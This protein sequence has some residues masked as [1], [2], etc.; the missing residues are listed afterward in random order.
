MD[1]I[2]DPTATADKKFQEA[3]GATPATH[4]RALWLNGVQEELVKLIEE[5]GIA[6][7]SS[8]LT[9]I[10]QALNRRFAISRPTIGA[11]TAM[12]GVRD[13]QAF[14]VD[15]GE[16]AG[17]WRATTSDIS[18]EVAA[19]SPGGVYRPWDGGDGTTGGVVRVDASNPSAAWWGGAVAAAP[20]V[21]QF[22]G[23]AIDCERA[24]GLSPGMSA[25]NATAVFQQIITD[26]NNSTGKQ[27]TI[28]GYEFPIGDSIGQLDVTA[29]DASLT[30]AKGA[31]L[32]LSAEITGSPLLT[33]TGTD[34]TSTTLIN[35]F[36]L[37]GLFIKNPDSYAGDFLH[38]SRAQFFDLRD[39]RLVGAVGIALRQEIH[40]DSMCERV[41][42][43]DCGDPDNDKPGH[44]LGDDDDS[45]YCNN[46]FFYGYHNENMPGVGLELGG[47]C[48]GNM[49]HGFKFHGS[50]AFDT[51]LPQLLLKGGHNTQFVGGRWLNPNQ[52][53]IELAVAASGQQAN[54][55][56]FTGVIN[57]AGSNGSATEGYGVRLSAGATIRG[58]IFNVAFGF[59]TENRDGDIFIEGAGQRGNNFAGCT[60]A[61]M[62]KAFGS[63][64]QLPTS[65][66]VNPAPP[67]E[68]TDAE[69]NDIT[70]YLNTNIKYK[71]LV[72]FN[73]TQAI[74]V[75]ALNSTAAGVWRKLSDNTTANTP[76]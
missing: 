10:S 67:I 76:A 51:E 55:N 23:S 14:T 70:S 71:G 56:I 49:F 6:P 40:W 45:E 17:Q 65:S 16:G 42:I 54:G 63:G 52:N 29:R 44:L 72:V 28:P 58:N 1:R 19:D 48:R 20:Y 60:H 24:Y 9:Q 38:V 11:V 69:L 46:L 33:C 66:N 30:F 74:P 50:Q 34:I 21:L 53:G 47:R 3:S 4:L 37:E 41:V 27:F 22:T 59:Q 18:T 75:Y 64:S 15:S 32:E 5:E 26:L 35:R 2:Q 57:N 73:T 68:A 39:V 62:E 13:G 7:S 61:D 12:T 31:S 25:A 36:R 43:L 8:D